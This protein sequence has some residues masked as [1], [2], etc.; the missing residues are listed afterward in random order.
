MQGE[1]QGREGD[2]AYREVDIT[3]DRSTANQY[4]VQATPTII[5]L[6][7]AGDVVD[8]FVGVPEENELERAIDQAIS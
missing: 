5:V 8:I 4:K 3:K 2:I 6:D 1:I 7:P